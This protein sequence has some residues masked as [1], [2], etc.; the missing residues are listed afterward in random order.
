M[1]ASEYGR[2]FLSEIFIGIV[3]SRK[4]PRTKCHVKRNESLLRAVLLTCLLHLVSSDQIGYSYNQIA[5]KNNLQNRNEKLNDIFE[6]DKQRMRRLSGESSVMSFYRPTKQ[7]FATAL[8]DNHP[9]AL[10][11]KQK[12]HENDTKM[13]LFSPK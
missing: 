12:R 1:K 9:V 5:T 11:G 8:D 7:V 10:E 13:S 2:T 3:T 6:N 4:V